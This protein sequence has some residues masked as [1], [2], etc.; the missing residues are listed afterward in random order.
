MQ[1]RKDKL[2][3]S[4]DYSDFNIFVEETGTIEEIPIDHMSEIE[5]TFCNN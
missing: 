1:E 2:D 3:K 5:G 4:D